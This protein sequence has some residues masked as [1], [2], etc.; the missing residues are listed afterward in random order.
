MKKIIFCLPVLLCVLTACDRRPDTVHLICKTGIEQTPSADT[1]VKSSYDVIVRFLDDG[2][3]IIVDGVEYLMDQ[4]YDA[5]VSFYRTEPWYNLQIG[6]RNHATKYSLG[7][8]TNEEFARY[9]SCE[10]VSE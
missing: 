6:T 4:E 5:R 7:I 10:Q 3:V 1:N 8:P 9:T 2:A